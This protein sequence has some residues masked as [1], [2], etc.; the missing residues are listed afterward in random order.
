ML[1]ARKF[2]KGT[3]ESK[4]KREPLERERERE[5]EKGEG[6]SEWVLRP[7]APRR[8]TLNDERLRA[9]VLSL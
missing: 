5:R 7:L 9:Q 4:R 1:T 8:A 6:G 2:Q 3:E